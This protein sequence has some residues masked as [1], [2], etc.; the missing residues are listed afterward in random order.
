MGN[1]LFDNGPFYG[2]KPIM[3][4]DP[5]IRKRFSRFIE[6]SALSMKTASIQAGLGETYVRDTI[7]RDRGSE[8]GVKK[9]VKAIN[10]EAIHFVID[11]IG[12]LSD[13]SFET[14][15]TRQIS[16]MD[17]QSTIVKVA[18]RV[19]AGAEIRP[20]FEQIGPDGLFEIEVDFPVLSDAI[21]FEVEG[22]S[23]WPRYDPGDIVIC[24]EEGTDISQVIGW[25]AA[26]RTR[27]GRR[28]LKRIRRGSKPGLFNLE[29]HNASPIEDV[30]IAWVA[31]IDHVVRAAKWRRLDRGAQTRLVAKTV[32]RSGK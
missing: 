31:Q 23:M 1:F 29:S 21:A 20:E 10:P 32:K 6:A 2:H 22:D 8:A 17:S 26:V 13:F 5:G 18:G 25:E 30:E 12:H 28:F 15:L 9:V 19:G 27:D 24:G 7:E 3:T 16:D 4:L 11:G 14:D